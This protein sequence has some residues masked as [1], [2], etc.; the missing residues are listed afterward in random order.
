MSYKIIG[1]SC[2]DLTADLKKDPH[3]QIIPL[4]LQVEHTQVIDDET[5]DQK[6][7]LELVRS[8]S[9]CPQTACPS[10]EKF[11]EAF[12]CDVDQIF[13]ITL[14]EHLSGTYN[15]AVLAKKL[16]EE[17]HGQE[18]KNIA[19]FSSDSASS[20][21][22]N[23]ALYIQSLCQAS[24][25]FEEIVEKTRSFIKNM[26]TY[27]VLESLDTLRKNG[28]LTGLQAFFATALNIKP[29]MGA[30]SGVIIKLDQARGIN[31]ALTRMADIAI[32]EAGETKDK[33]L[34]IAHCNNPERAEVVKNEM[35][36]QATFKDVII[37]ETAG[38]ATV[39]AS[40][41]GIIVAL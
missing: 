37:T 30:D 35:C 16:Y 39:Y 34:I 33:V 41:G 26:K 1:D 15:S 32:R 24:L 20:G 36:R 6:K 23:I 22:L 2:L 17:E 5:F 8:S 4:T 19:V 9:E 40:D 7:F 38:V 3:F 18:G 10:P 31:K 27:F 14:S 28:R 29:V 11:K 12:E 13:V 25:P 21:E